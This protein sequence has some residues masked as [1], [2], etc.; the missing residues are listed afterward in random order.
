M[1]IMNTLACASSIVQNA[2]V[3]IVPKYPDGPTGLFPFEYRH[4]DLLDYVLR[5]IDPLAPMVSS[6]CLFIYSLLFYIIKSNFY[7]FSQICMKI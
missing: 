3:V 4:K 1:F 7:K 2:H 5:M 6:T